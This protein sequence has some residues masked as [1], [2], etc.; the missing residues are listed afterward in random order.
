MATLNASR[1]REHRHNKFMAALKGIDLDEGSKQESLKRVQEEMERL[2]AE[3]DGV[4]PSRQT[5]QSDLS[6]FGIM[7]V[8]GG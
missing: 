6:A 5:E 2:E 4:A 1:D 3:R 8:E 7:V